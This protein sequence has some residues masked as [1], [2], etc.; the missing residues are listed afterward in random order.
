[1]CEDRLEHENGEKT[2]NLSEWREAQARE[3]REVK[4][5]ERMRMASLDSEAYA[6]READPDRAYAC[7]TEG[8]RLAGLLGEPWWALYYDNKRVEALLHFKRDFR[9]VLEMAVACVLEARKP[10]N[11][12]FPGRHAI[13]DNLLA[14]TIGID[15]EGHADRIREAIDYLDKDIPLEHDAARYLLMARE[16]IFAMERLDVKATYESC[17]KELNFCSTD[18]TQWRAAHYGG[19]VYCTLCQIASLTDNN[20]SLAEWAGTAEEL[21]KDQGH[22]CE[23]A[24][25]VAWQAVAAM[26]D[27]ATKAK[28]LYLK[29]TALAARIKMPPKRGYFD[30]L[31][32]YHT[33]RGDLEGALQV[34]DDELASVAGR[35]QLLWETRVRVERCG[36]LSAV[37][38]LTQADLDEARLVA[39]KLG[40]PAAHLKQL[41]ELES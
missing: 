6:A 38:Q 18:R 26:S 14:A 15:A 36:M 27:D 12:A 16:R 28:R 39:G 24:E 21:A 41:D 33:N 22:Q 2:M 40:L 20:D 25:A 3:F 1:M 35:G 8:R 30:A 5:A 9:N 11:Q 34:R 4:D 13:W 29:A 32:S 37:D 23:Q 19:F 17:M 31:V 10:T 7:Y